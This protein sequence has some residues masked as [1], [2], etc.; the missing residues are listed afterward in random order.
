M[1]DDKDRRLLLSLLSIFYSR[2]LI[3]QQS[4]RLCEGQLYYVPPHGSHQVLS[5]DAVGSSLLV[6]HSRQQ[7]PLLQS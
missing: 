4:Y 5:D 1:T 7:T 6:N 2:D 3:G